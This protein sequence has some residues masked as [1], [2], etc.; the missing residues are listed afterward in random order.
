MR[1]G[2]EHRTLCVVRAVLWAKNF[3]DNTEQHFTDYYC[4]CV[5]CVYSRS[6]RD[7]NTDIVR[8]R[9][10]KS[11]QMET[12][13]NSSSV[14][15]Q[16]EWRKRH[17]GSDTLMYWYFE[18]HNRSFI[19]AFGPAS[20]C[21]PSSSAFAF[22]LSMKTKPSAERWPANA[23]GKL[24]LWYRMCACVNATNRFES[25]NPIMF[26]LM[27]RL[28]ISLY[29]HASSNHCLHRNSKWNN[30]YSIQFGCGRRHIVINLTPRSARH[31]AQHIS[32]LSLAIPLT[33]ASLAIVIGNTF[34]HM[35]DIV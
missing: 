8:E 19:R 23:V 1:P 2:H 11:K 10:E 27:V 17:T 26:Q 28:S 20:L 29:V 30:G 3:A 16:W 7:N 6:V 12:N 33:H 9:D 14:D 15:R 18:F 32:A 21:V 25:R 34:V 35:P 5:K 4:S 24:N 13:G 22:D 31:D